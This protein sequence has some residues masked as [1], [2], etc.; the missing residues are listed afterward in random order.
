MIE[1]IKKNKII[2]VTL[3]LLLVFLTYIITPVNFVSAYISGADKYSDVLSDLQKDETFDIRQ[4]PVSPKDYSLKVIQIAESTDKELFVYVYQPSA[5]YKN[6]VASYIKLALEPYL[7]IEADVDFNFYSLTFCNKYSTLYKYKVNDLKVKSDSIRYYSITSIYRPFDESVDNQASYDNKVTNVDFDVC[8]KYTFEDK[9][10]KTV[11]T[12]KDLETITI[13][14]KFVG[15]VRYESGWK[16]IYDESCDNHFV[17]FNTDR[18]IDDLYEAEVFFKR[19]NYLSTI[20]LDE[21]ESFGNIIDDEVVVSYQD[22]ECSYNGGGLFSLT[23][24]WNSIQKIDDFCSSVNVSK[25]V[26]SGALFNATVANTITKEGKEALKGKQWVLRFYSSSYNYYYNPYSSLGETHRKIE[27]T[28]VSDVS[29]LRLKFMCDGKVYN[30]GVLDNMQTGSLNPINRTVFGINFK[31]KI[32][33]KMILIC[34]LIILAI[35][36]L[37]PILPYV[38]KT[39]FMVIALPFRAIKTLIISIKKTRKKDK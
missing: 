3:S 37:S 4:Y 2:L 31:Y 1:F 38:I 19:Q 34:I 23:Y 29:I 33:W 20:I 26:Y 21:E 13:T 25:N 6:Y 12:C 18:P 39:V 9:D 32:N 11:I 14:D 10:G 5:N 15:F 17:A 35:I 16:G 22:K 8:K 24:K 28:I 27:Y 36:I 30:L 7:D